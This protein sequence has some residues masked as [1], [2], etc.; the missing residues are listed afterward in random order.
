MELRFLRQRPIDKYIADFL[1]PDFKLIIEIDGS[2]HDIKYD[3]DRVREKKLMSLGYQLLRFTER[4][5]MA[6]LNDALETIY[7]KLTELQ[8]H[9]PQ[10]SLK[11]GGIKQF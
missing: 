1:Q 6:N 2:S 10:P 5:I 4:D 7:L 8:N 11:R 9:S 3:N